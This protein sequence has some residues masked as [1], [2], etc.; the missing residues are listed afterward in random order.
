MSVT[1]HLWVAA[2]IL[3]ALSPGNRSNAAQ[4]SEI[5]EPTGIVDCLLLGTV[6]RVGGR[7][8]QTPRRPALLPASECKIRGG[9]FLLYDRA[10]YKTSLAHWTRQANTRGKSQPEAM[11][12]VAEIYAQGLGSKPDFAT[13]ASWYQRAADKGNTSAMISLANLYK[14]G[15]GV[16]LD[17]QKAQALYSK[18]FGSDTPI[19]FDPTSVKG[20]DQRVETL[21]AEVDEVR[22]QKVAVE[23]ALDATNQQLADARRA[24]ED[25]MT[26]VGGDSQQIKDLRAKVSSQ[27]EELSVYRANLDELETANSE[28]TSLR[29]QLAQQEI[30][31][32]RLQALLASAET[33]VQ[34]AVQEVERQH[35][36]LETKQADFNRKLA[37]TSADRESLQ[38]ASR[39]LESQRERIKSLEAG[40][41]KVEQERDLYAALADDT[42]TQEERAAVLTTR[43]ASLEQQSQSVESELSE[44]R[45][46]L[47]GARAALDDQIQLASQ[48]DNRSEAEIAARDAEIAALRAEVTRAVEEAGRHNDDIARLGNQSEQLEQLRFDL[49]REQ[50]QTARLGELLAASRADMEQS[51]RTSIDLPK[52]GLGLNDEIDALRTSAEAGDQSSR[53]KLRERE[54]ELESARWSMAEV[55]T[56]A[57]R[58]KQDFERYRSQ[59]GDTAAR[60]SQVVDELRLAVADSRRA[61]VELETQLSFASRQ[62][63]TAESDLAAEVEQRKKLQDQLF[64]ERGRGIADEQKLEALEA[65][66]DKQS[67]QV[68]RLENEILRVQTQ[69]DQFKAQ[70]DDQ[71]EIDQAKKVRFEGPRIVLSEPTETLLASTL[72]LTRGTQPARGLAV[73][74]A[75]QINQFKTVRGQVMAPA[76]IAQFTFNGDPVLLDEDNVFAH[77][78]SL[79]SDSMLVTLVA[80]DR[81]GMQAAKQ[82]EYHVDAP[83]EIYSNGG[84]F[85]ATR[86]E[87]LDHLRY[88]ALIIANQDYQEDQLLPDLQTPMADADAIGRILRERYNFEVEILRNATGAQLEDKLMRILWTKPKDNAFKDTAFAK[89]K[90]AILIYYAGHGAQDP[91]GLVEDAYYWAPVDANSVS[92][93]SWYRTDQFKMYMRNSATKQI[94]VVADSCYSGAMFRDALTKPKE[95]SSL[96]KKYL[97]K[98]TEELNSR[99]AITSGGFAPVL[100]GGGGG[101]S[102]FARA[103]MTVLERNNGLLSATVIHDQVS[104]MVLDRVAAYDRDDLEQTPYFGPLPGTEHKNGLFYLPAPVSQSGE[105]SELDPDATVAQTSRP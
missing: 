90:D 29:E 95:P 20:A 53:A 56:A 67:A 87:A 86:N 83:I 11:F 17:L 7:I 52:T 99:Y 46:E 72:Q 43:I 57:A 12:Y 73:L 5:K 10:N 39:E 60:Q 31:T 101:H 77:D 91:F 32:A 96:D 98:Y 70:I 69:R 15:V 24:L 22:K 58:A 104:Q 44:T 89:P 63:E 16:E 41:Q 65:D 37:D 42:A 100:D 93:S 21:L 59:I 4:E 48:D 6:R 97:T 64:D 102:V 92:P 3:L 62:L 30:E 78:F 80:E 76:G 71:D 74:P 19:A 94:L 55:E 9:D 2:A 54:Q 68:A 23:L 75:E 33:G 49:E 79:S 14:T 66:L 34:R 81:N 27:E 26:A 105:G 13:A 1:R 35:Q 51:K 8:I 61:R 103:F 25:A 18:A 50:G 45:D 47:E 38:T 82:F 85:Q 84:R 88:Y 28:L 36:S 40:L